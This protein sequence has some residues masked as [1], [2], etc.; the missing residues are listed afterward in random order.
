MPNSRSSLA[1]HLLQPIALMPVASL[2]CWLGN[3]NSLWQTL[4]WQ[5]GIALFSILPMLLAMQLARGLQ[6]ESFPLQALNAALGYLL[7]ATS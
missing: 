2:L 6:Q 4:C 3:G 7:L 1:V 5:C